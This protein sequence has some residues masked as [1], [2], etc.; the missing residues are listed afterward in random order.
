MG[1]TLTMLDLES[2]GLIGSLADALVSLSPCLI[3][4]EVVRRRTSVHWSRFTLT[5]LDLEYFSRRRL[6]LNLPGFTL[7]MLDLE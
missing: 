1:F 3:L 4:N 6:K 7:T 2:I 5:M